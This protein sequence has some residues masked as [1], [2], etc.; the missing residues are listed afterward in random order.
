[1]D[2]K[3]IESSNLFNQQVGQIKE[4]LSTLFSEH[5]KV[6]AQFN[7]FLENINKLNQALKENEQVQDKQVKKLERN[8]DLK[9]TYLEK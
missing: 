8:V 5:E 1:M 4:D 2:N 9:I 7:L 3:L 6:D